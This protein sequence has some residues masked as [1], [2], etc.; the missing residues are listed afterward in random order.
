MGHHGSENRKE[1]RYPF[2]ATA[3][4]ERS[5][6]ERVPAST[7]NVS[8]GGLLLRVEADSTMELGESVTCEV[9][10]YGNKPLQSW[11]RGRIVRVDKP[12]VAID[13]QS[14]MPP[15]GGAGPAA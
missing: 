4:I 14:K 1:P 6:G 5:T 3:I 13:F 8:G 9:K 15:C 10:L 7:V 2:C 11:G 12:L